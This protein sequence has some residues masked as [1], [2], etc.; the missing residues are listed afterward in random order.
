MRVAIVH[1]SINE[2]GG[3]ER[4]LLSLIKL[5]PAADIFSSYADKWILNKFFRK[6]SSSRL[7][8]SFVQNTSLVGHNTVC[9]V[10]SPLIWRL[11]DFNNYDLVI[12]NSFYLLCNQ[13]DIKRAIH[14]QYI[15]CPPKNLFKF[16]PKRR[17]QKIVP[18][19][20]LLANIY[21]K[22]LKSSPH[23]IV[24]SKYMQ[25]L[26]YTLF[27]VRTKVIYPPV[28]IPIVLPFNKAMSKY[29]LIVSR[30]DRSK[31]IELAI[32]ACNY[33]RMPLK[34]VGVTNEPKYEVY[35]K[36]ISGPTIEFLGYRDDKEIKN[37]YRSA[38]AFLFTSKAEDFGIAPVEAMANGVPIIAYYGGGAK[39]TVIHKKTGLFFFEHNVDSLIKAI[40]Y[41]LKYPYFKV[42][43]L[44]NHAKKFTEEK[45]LYEMNNYVNSVI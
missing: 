29:F 35:L 44:Y 21:R 13:I 20:S 3:A 25:K 39:E 26:I 5:Y 43:T 6:I 18:Y 36:S 27:K 38:K 32:L 11:F 2:F 12:S 9:Q 30:L 4:V 34:I 16:I 42:E 41:F 24:D 10:L 17:L 1:D 45:F 37:L 19:T 40:K 8:F 31:S 14:I 28:K 22:A 23:V 15:C 7:H 33:L